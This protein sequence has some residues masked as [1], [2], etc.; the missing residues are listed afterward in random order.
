ML[1]RETPQPKTW[2]NLLSWIYVCLLVYLLIAAVSVIG[3]GFKETTQGDAEQLFA[4]ATNPFLGLLVGILGT[5]LIQ[6]SSTVT[7]IIVGLV[8]GG[9]PISVAIPMIMGANLGTSVTNTLVSL[10]YVGDPQGFNR[11][12]AAATVLDFFNLTAVV[13]LFPIELL[14]HPLETI[15]Y[16]L[17]HWMAG[18]LSINVTRFNPVPLLVYPVIGIVEQS[19]SLLP[20]IFCGLAQIF[21]GISTI[22]LVIMLLGKR[23]KQLLVG[24]AKAM[25]HAM[26][27]RGAISGIFSG[28]VVTM[29]VQSSSTT[30]SL[31]IPFAGSG[32]I[33]MRQIYPFT[34]GANIGTCVTALLAATAFTG[35]ESIPALEIALVHLL[36]NLVGVTLIY[37]VPF[38]RSIPIDCANWISEIAGQRKTLAMVYVAGVFFV[39]PGLLLGCSWLLN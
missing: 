20:G 7:S 4:F 5:A 24:K 14:F 10:G 37:G 2:Q 36:F 22:V 35:A 9:L 3:N 26:L 28:A 23:L 8:A 25:L 34:L 6:S 30:T 18:D 33:G 17:A 12:F 27:G 1:L 11:A 21:L 32:A 39:A 38:L 15:S 31:M 16:H 19:T 29:M 13:I